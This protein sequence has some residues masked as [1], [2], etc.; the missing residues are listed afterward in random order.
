MGSS[1]VSV[2]YNSVNLEKMKAVSRTHLR[3]QGDD[4]NIG[5]LGRIVEYKGHMH[6]MEVAKET[7][8]RLPNTKFFIHGPTSEL[9]G[10]DIAYL[11]GLREKRIVLGLEDR[12]FF[13][14]SYSDVTEVMADTDVV[15]CCSPYDNFSRV[16]FEAMA[17]GVPVVA[18]DTGGTREV[19]ISEK[20]ALLVPNLDARAMSDAVIRLIHDRGLRERIVFGGRQ[21]VEH[22]FDTRTNA[23]AILNIYGKVLGARDQNVATDV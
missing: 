23:R 17:C 11:Y 5:M 13:A 21:T 15:L 10:D 1:H 22:L 20:N 14:G 9:E 16:L 4:Y 3:G 19:V 7:V 18:F 12:L 6:F 8:R 2:V